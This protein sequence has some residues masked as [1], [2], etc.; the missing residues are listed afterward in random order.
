M[1]IMSIMFFI[2]NCSFYGAKWD[3]IFPDMVC[4]CCFFRCFSRDVAEG[5]MVVWADMAEN[6]AWDSYACDNTCLC[7]D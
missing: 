6:S 4:H 2:W 7:S 5:M 3:G 1:D